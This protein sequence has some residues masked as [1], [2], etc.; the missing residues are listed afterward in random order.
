[1]GEELTSEEMEAWRP[2]VTAATVVIGALDADM[3]AAFG[4]T[5]FDHG[6]LLMLS[7]QNRR[8]ARMTDIARFLRVEPS[9]ITY[10]MRRL[11]RLGLVERVPDP[12]DGRVSHARIT[13][14]GLRLLRDAWPLHRD[15]I[16]RYF[17]DH[18][19]AGQLCAVADV[20]G[21]IVRA[22]HP[23]ALLEPSPLLLKAGLKPG[24]GRVGENRNP[25]RHGGPGRETERDG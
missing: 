18:V 17:L 7:V 20:F 12:H 23:G 16:R 4:I 14:K 13:I 8:R 25:G 10:R 6:L 2:F 9:N 3:R 15:G 5:H 21:S 22:L 11:D 24:S 1:M 19:P